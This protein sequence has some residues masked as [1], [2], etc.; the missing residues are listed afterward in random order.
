[1]GVLSFVLG[2][3]RS[4]ARMAQPG[5]RTPPQE[6]IHKMSRPSRIAVC[7]SLLFPLA[8]TVVLPLAIAQFSGESS[9]AANLVV[10]IQGHPAIKRKNWTSFAPLTFGVD[11]QTGDLLRVDQS[12]VANAVRSDLEL[13]DVAAG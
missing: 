3:A 6:S 2:S 1:M 5:A 11:L 8:L 4:P 13:L 10:L 7:L 9:Q 12:S